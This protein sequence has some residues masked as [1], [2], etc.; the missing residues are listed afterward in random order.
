MAGQDCEKPRHRSGALPSLAPG[1]AVGGETLDDRLFETVAPA[2]DP[3]RAT[4]ESE[5]Q[6]ALAAALSR[7]AP[8]QCVLIEHAYFMGYTQSELAEHFNL[9]LGTVKTR[10]RTGML[11]MREHLQHL[12]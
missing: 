8:G 12:V 2:P 10:I 3:E 4:S 7:L 6:R 5:Q 9:P 1:H 11:A